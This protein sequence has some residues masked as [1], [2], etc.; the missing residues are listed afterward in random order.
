MRYHGLYIAAYAIPPWAGGRENCSEWKGLLFPAAS[1]CFGIGFHSGD[2]L[3]EISTTKTIPSPKRRVCFIHS[4][5]VQK[6]DL[7][8]SCCFPHDHFFTGNSVFWPELCIPAVGLVPPRLD[9]RVPMPE[10]TGAAG[11]DGCSSYAGGEKPLSQ[12]EGDGVLPPGDSPCETGASGCEEEAWV[13]QWECSQDPGALQGI[14]SPTHTLPG[15]HWASPTPPSRAPHRE[16]GPSLAS[17]VQFSPPMLLLQLPAGPASAF[18]EMK[19]HL[20]HTG[21]L[22]SESTKRCQGSRAQLAARFP[23]TTRGSTPGKTGTGLLGRG[24][25]ALGK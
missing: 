15:D 8:I 16:Q 14:A 25:Q 22:V 13:L 4:L 2:I 9:P 1:A 10:D 12:M 18:S 24:C 20:S 19:L 11:I 17:R 6:T 5:L 7:F 21:N 3:K 23:P